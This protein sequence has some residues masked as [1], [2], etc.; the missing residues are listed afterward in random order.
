MLGKQKKE[1]LI[2][3]ELKIVGYLLSSSV[4]ARRSVITQV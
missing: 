4:S 1:Q 2:V 3:Q